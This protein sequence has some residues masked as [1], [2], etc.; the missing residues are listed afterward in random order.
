MFMAAVLSL[1][2]NAATI[3][4]T[5]DFSISNGNPNSQWA[6]RDNTTLLTLQTPLNNG[7]TLI[8]ALS[9][10][11]WGLGNNLNSNTPDLFKAQVNEPV[12]KPA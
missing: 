6:Y 10:G 8:P 1:T 5:N 12:K 4:L 7:N 11:Y 9:N 3:S 2:V